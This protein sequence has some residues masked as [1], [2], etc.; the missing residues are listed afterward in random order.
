MFPN[1]LSVEAL[2]LLRRRV[3]RGTAEEVGLGLREAS[4]PGPASSCH[5]VLSSCRFLSVRRSFGDGLLTHFPAG[6]RRRQPE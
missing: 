1:R 5:S 6:F 4:S 2:A 3:T